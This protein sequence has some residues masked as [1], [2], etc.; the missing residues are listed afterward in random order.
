MRTF[1]SRSVMQNTLMTL[2]SRCFDSQQYTQYFAEKYLDMALQERTKC[3]SLQY[4][5]EKF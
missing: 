2:I 1:V 4:F 5:C 3:A